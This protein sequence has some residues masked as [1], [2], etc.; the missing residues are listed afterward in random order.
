MSKARDI[1]RAGTALS[2]V[3]ATELGY[4]DG[5]TSNVQTQINAKLA[6]ATAASTYQPLVANV[7]DTEI[8]YLDGVTSAIQT[9]LNQKPEYV[10]GKNKAINGDFAINQRGFSTTGSN[11]VFF[12]DRFTTTLFNGTI[13]FTTPTIA[14]GSFANQTSNKVLRITSG[15]SANDAGLRT[16]IEDVSTFAG[17]TITVSFWI[18]SSGTTYA[19]DLVEALQ[20]FGTGGSANVYAYADTTGKSFGSSWT[21]LSFQIAVPSVAGKTI[22]AGNHLSIRIDPTFAI[23][24]G[25]WIEIT[26]IQVEAGST[27]TPFT[28]A[29]GNISSELAAC[30]RYY[31]RRAATSTQG[32]APYAAGYFNFAT[33]ANYAYQFETEKRVQP[34]VTFGPSVGQFMAGYNGNAGQAAVTLTAAN[35]SRFGCYLTLV[36]SGTPFTAGQATTLQDAGSA[37]SYIEVSA[38]L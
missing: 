5:V 30:K 38:E 11:D 19:S 28:T 12:A 2:S 35:I 3:D 31:E 23:A 16:K 22:G 21:R 32:Y 29:T 37:V 6:T 36:P 8:G 4:L 25:E 24:N 26:H 33:A 9:Q 20:Y 1:A 18:R 15:S 10:A 17:Q 34:T 13:T 14:Y 27:A 7:S